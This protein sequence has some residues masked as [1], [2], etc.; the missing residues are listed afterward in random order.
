MEIFDEAVKCYEKA[1]EIDPEN[2][3]YKKNLGLAKEKLQ[4]ATQVRLLLFRTYVNKSIVSSEETG[5]DRNLIK[6][7]SV[8][9]MTWIKC[10][11]DAGQ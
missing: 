2:E 3:G 9:R 6:E 1:L 11:T 7:V 10:N 5:I 8:N 4:A